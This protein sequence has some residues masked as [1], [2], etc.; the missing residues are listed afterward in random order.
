MGHMENPYNK[1]PV[2]I[3]GGAQN[4]VSIARSLGRNGVKVYL[5]V[6]QGENALFSRFVRQSFPYT[7]SKNVHGFWKNLLFN[8][9]NQFLQGSIIFP[10]NDDAVEFV[11]L[12]QDRLKT[13]YISWRIRIL[14]YDWQCWI[15]K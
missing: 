4:S 1:P 5:S 3:L 10:C 14:K 15:K 13:L 9:H 12:N 2:L 11:A 8:P 6:R 7:D